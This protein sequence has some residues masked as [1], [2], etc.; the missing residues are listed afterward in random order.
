VW[1]PKDISSCEHEVERWGNSSEYYEKESIW[2]G[3]VSRR[4]R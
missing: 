3:G 1:C 2:G 4:K